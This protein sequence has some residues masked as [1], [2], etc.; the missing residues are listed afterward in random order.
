M[1]NICLTIIIGIF[2]FNIS[3][4]ITYAG[5]GCCS[6]HGGQNYCDTSVGKWVCRDG[7]YSPSCTCQKVNNNTNNNNRN[8]NNNNNNLPSQKI[9]NIKKE[10]NNETKN[11]NDFSIFYLIGGGWLVYCF[12]KKDKK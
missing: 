6:H 7:T 10:T 5:R 11:E 12:T 9:S 3:P 4:P 8:N 2:L 1:K